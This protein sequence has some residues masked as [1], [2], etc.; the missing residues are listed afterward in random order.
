[1]LVRPYQRAPNVPLF[2][3]MCREQREE[4]EEHL[5]KL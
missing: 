5:F 4:K 3:I 2:A 1:M